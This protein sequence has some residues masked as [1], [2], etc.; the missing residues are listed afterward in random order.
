ML[1][2]GKSPQKYF[3][4]RQFAFFI[5]HVINRLIKAYF[6]AA[7]K[8]HDL[9]FYLIFFLY[10]L[11]LFFS[12]KVMIFKCF[13]IKLKLCSLNKISKRIVF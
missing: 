6:D 1:A 4:S 7:I 8:C 5:F 10:F 3:L 9:W 13:S 11:S 12:Y 2:E